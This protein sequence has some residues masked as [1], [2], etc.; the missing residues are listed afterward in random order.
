MH[1]SYNWHA[2]FFDATHEM[3]LSKPGRQMRILVQYQASY[4][5]LRVLDLKTH[6][7]VPGLTH[8]LPEEVRA[9]LVRY[10]AKRWPGE[11]II[12]QE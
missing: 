2:T 10:C 8:Q 4:P 9:E 6:M 11:P 7:P 5:R 12:R 1:L 3:V